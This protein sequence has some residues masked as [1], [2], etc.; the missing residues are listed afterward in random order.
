MIDNHLINISEL[1]ELMGL[2]VN[3]LYTWVSQRR[4]PYVKIGRLT[5]FNAGVID[6]WINAHSVEPLNIRERR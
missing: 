4:I 5:K 3:T 6:S 2:S 1:S